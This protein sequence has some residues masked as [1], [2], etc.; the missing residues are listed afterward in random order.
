MTDVP[1][2]DLAAQYRSIEPEINTAINEV[3]SS[4]S[5]ILGDRVKMFENNID[6]NTVKRLSH[7]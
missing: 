2:V 6:I 5:F 1:F 7:K 3:L 4:C